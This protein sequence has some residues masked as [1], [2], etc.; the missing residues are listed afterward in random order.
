MAASAARSGDEGGFSD[1]LNW[2]GHEQR[3]LSFCMPF[4]PVSRVRQGQHAIID[5]DQPATL[6][7]VPNTAH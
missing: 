7:E 3:R 6:E 2:L 4:E 1:T 5:V